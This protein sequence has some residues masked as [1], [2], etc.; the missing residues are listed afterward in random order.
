MVPQTKGRRPLSARDR[1]QLLLV[2][3]VVIAWPIVFV[4]LGA[5]CPNLGPDACP[6]T[7]QHTA[8]EV[9][10]YAFTGFGFLIAGLAA[11]RDGKRHGRYWIATAVLAWSALALTVLHPPHLDAYLT[12]TITLGFGGVA[13]GVWLW[14]K[15]F[16]VVGI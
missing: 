14:V 15:T 9:A 10:L 6:A 13:L 4:G 12:A 8:I 16:G 7:P 2:G 3:A 1:K 5:P 11:C